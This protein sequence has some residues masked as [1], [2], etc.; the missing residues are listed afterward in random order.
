MPI[1]LLAE[2]NTDYWENWTVKVTVKVTVERQLKVSP[3][4]I[5][6]MDAAMSISA[7][8]HIQFFRSEEDQ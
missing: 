4:S 3:N 2:S 8:S 1:S 6:S 7:E 5:S